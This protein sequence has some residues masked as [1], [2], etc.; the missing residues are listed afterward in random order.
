MKHHILAT[1]ATIGLLTAATASTA[2]SVSLPEE[3]KPVDLV[4]A[5]D[6][7]GSMSG[8]IDSARQRLWDVVNELGQAQPMPDLRIALITFG[9]PRYGAAGGFVNIDLPFTRDL[10]AVNQ[11]LF[12]LGTDGGDEYVAR[13]IDTAVRQL[14]WSDR[15]D[16]LR[17]LFVAGN[18]SAEQDPQITIKAA[19]AMAA[20][21]DIVV[22]TIYCG[23]E[24]DNI[25]GE[26]LKVATLAGGQYASIDQHAAAVANV[27]TP[28][29]AELA[30]LN[31]ELNNTYVAY[32][33]AG[34]QHRENQ[35]AQ[36]QNAAAMSAPAAASRTV[37]KASALYDATDWDLVDAYRAGKEVEEEALPAP[38]QA[39]APEAR[40]EHMAELARKRETIKQQIA[41]LGEARSAYIAEEKAR[42]GG[43][44]GL[45]DAISESVRELAAE[46]GFKFRGE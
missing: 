13:A 5:L 19:A 22:N 11:A 1:L 3:R 23:N 30:Q 45:D 28:M 41:Q 20:E 7:S 42:Q 12:A 9:T 34:E 14:Q 37:A 2:R 4:I 6:T 18:E 31:A 17:L 36:D 43:P 38:L 27:A 40:E 39:M 24:G 25:A 16:A 44:E 46:R 21:H 33:Q 26:W 15:D 8:L 35:Q 10:D 32:G 29:D